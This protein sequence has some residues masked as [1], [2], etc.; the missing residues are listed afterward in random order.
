MNTKLV[1]A[2]SWFFSSG[3]LFAETITL[4]LIVPDSGWT[5]ECK[6]VYQK[7]SELIALHELTAPPAFDSEIS[8]VMNR[9]SLHAPS[10]IARHYVIGK[11][12]NWKRN[13]PVVY[14]ESVDSVDLSEAVILYDNGE[15]VGAYSYKMGDGWV[16]SETY[17]WLWIKRYPWVYM[18]S[19][20]SRSYQNW[21][22]F[23]ESI[24][25]GG[26]ESYN[27]WVPPGVWYWSGVRSYP[28]VYDYVSRTWIPALSQQK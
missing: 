23:S 19:Y 2:F 6:S 7:G 27:V 16:Y 11:T 24:E 8:T 10:V 17:G 5:I 18:N 26:E 4:T 12:W 20:D 15:S 3:I 25:Y 14:I 1:L 28:W 21:V 13:D 22:L 9:V